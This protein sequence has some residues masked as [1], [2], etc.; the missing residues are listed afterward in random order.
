MIKNSFFSRNNIKF[1]KLA[2]IQSVLKSSFNQKQTQNDFKIRKQIYQNFIEEQKYNKKKILKDDEYL[3]M[4]KEE[5]EKLLI[6]ERRLH[7]NIP[8]PIN[9]K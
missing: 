5:N 8:I 6:H 4:L 2:F 3:K 1:D 7:C 9:L